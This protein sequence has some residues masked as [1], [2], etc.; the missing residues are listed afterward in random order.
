LTASLKESARRIIPLAWP[1]FI[2]QLAVLG[3]STID[4]VLVARH[5]ALDLAALAV[6]ASSYVTIFIG[7][8]GVV[9]AIGPIAGRL[10]GAGEDHE[11]GAQVQQAAWLA[12]ALA[13]AGST[14]LLVPEPF[15]WLS[16]APPEVAG[17]VRGYLGALAFALP[18][19][20]LFA[21]YRGFN[22]AVS[23]PKAVMALQLGGLACKIP[24]SALLVGRFGVAGCG[25]ATAIVMWTQVI[26]AVVVMKRD[27]FYDRF[28]LWRH[29]IARPARAPLLAQLRLGIPM[30]LSIL[31]EVTGFSFMALFIS[32]VSPTA[33]AGHQIAAN[34]V[35]LMFMMPL[36]LAN[37][38]STLV[39]QR[40]G[41]G[42]PADAT[43]L[44]WHGLQ[45]AA[46]A[47]GAL[48]I[49]VFLLRGTIV[50][51]YTHD[52]VIAAAALPLLA[53][54]ALFHLGDA[55]QC[56]SNFVLRGWHVATLPVVIYALSLWCIGLGGGTVLGFG[57]GDL[58]PLGARGFWMASTASL[59]VAA[60][61]LIALLA[62]VVRQKR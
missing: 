34:L 56:V 39:A 14:L 60:S 4:T 9:L 40:I 36:G 57:V 46:L 18:A 7:L 62:W 21:V 3:F 20:L 33:V 45:I 11:A 5:S 17:K 44:G 58:E 49:V 13:L 12:L 10:H 51:L 41:A 37:G 28:A 23:R 43:R 61:G 48:G 16:K 35:S 53:W 22:N 29:G 6:G 2:G 15:L 52:E 50:R 59:V 54:V 8:M 26:L 27:R 31:I 32:R 47:A 1:V 55:L 42:D 30:G 38:T 24:L 19:A 25:I